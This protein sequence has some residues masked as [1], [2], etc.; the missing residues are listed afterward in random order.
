ML[1]LLWVWIQ[2]TGVFSCG[3]LAGGVGTV[4]ALMLI[5]RK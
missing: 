1:E 3:A 5:G 2:V 4:A